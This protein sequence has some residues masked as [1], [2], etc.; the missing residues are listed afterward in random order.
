MWTIF[1]FGSAFFAGVTSI[2]AK[3]G[4]R[5]TD[6]TVA[7][8]IRTIM[9]LLFSWLMVFIVG[10]QDLSLI[11]IYVFGIGVICFQFFSQTADMHIHCADVSGVIFAPHHAEQSFPAEHPARVPGQHHQKVKLF[12]C[13]IGGATVFEH[14]TLGGVD[15]K[16]PYFDLI[17]LEIGSR[18]A[19]GP[20]EN[21]PDA[22]FQ[23]QNI[24]GL[25]HIVIGPV[26]KAD[27]LIHPFAFGG[28][29]N[30]RHIGVFPDLPADFQPVDRCV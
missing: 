12:G 28:E 27:E 29:H 26:F 9:V 19:A 17:V 8:A 16:I 7:T 23:L 2:L 3:C 20:A 30:H 11:H 24:K 4:I 18:L 1:A 5:K 14:R 10:S 22:G 13:E 15:E 6:S 21:G 25:G